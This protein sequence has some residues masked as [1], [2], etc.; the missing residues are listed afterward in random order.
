MTR[1]VAHPWFKQLE[2]KFYSTV[3]WVLIGNYSF[4]ENAFNTIPLVSAKTSSTVEANIKRGTIQ[5]LICLC[6]MIVFPAM[7]QQ[8]EFYA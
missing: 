7:G 3:C 4:N 6:D 5:N 8:L 2:F 1:E